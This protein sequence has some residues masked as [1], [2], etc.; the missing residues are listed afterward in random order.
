VRRFSNVDLVF[1]SLKSEESFS[2]NLWL[3]L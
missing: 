3:F 2:Q 1:V